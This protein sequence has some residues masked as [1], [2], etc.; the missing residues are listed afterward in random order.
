VERLREV[1][2]SAHDDRL[3]T[4]N[5]ADPLNLT[6]VITGEER[7]R[8]SAANRIVYRNGVPL[9][10][11]KATCFGRL[12]ISSPN[13]LPMRR[14]QQPAAVCPSSAGLSVGCEVQCLLKNWTARSCFSAAARLP[15]VPRFLRRPVFGSF[16][17]E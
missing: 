2:R 7:I 15:N 11:W 6:G 4:I 17:R 9:R 1:R 5:A 13:W 10:P 12:E 16:F 14:P 3:V 8:A